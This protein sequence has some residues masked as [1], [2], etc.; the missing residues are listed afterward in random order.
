MLGQV[1]SL[2]LK[3]EV[4]DLKRRSAGGVLVG[5][6]VMLLSLASLAGLFALYLWL[7]TRLGAW[8]AALAIAVLLAL[9]GGIVLLVG[10]GMMRRHHK[11]KQELDAY[12]NTLLS[13]AGI[14][15]K[16]GKVVVPVRI[17][18]LAG[19][20]GIVIGRQVRK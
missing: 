15:T 14:G 18:V 6:G 7:S 16:Q 5:S 3:R 1:L 17:V 12:M 4:A 2:L 9:L 13:S 19:L 10:R 8:Q 11:I 20:V